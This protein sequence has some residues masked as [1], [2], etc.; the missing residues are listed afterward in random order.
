MLL[1][2][3]KFCEISTLLEKVLK[4][5]NIN[6]VSNTYYLFACNEFS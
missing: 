3:V 1:D 6:I 4:I 2:V 5:R